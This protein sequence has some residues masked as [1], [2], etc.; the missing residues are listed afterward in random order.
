MSADALPFGW[1]EV[2]S[3]G[4]LPYYWNAT[5]GEASWSRPQFS[6]AGARPDKVRVAHLLLKHTGSRRP[7]TRTGELVTRSQAQATERLGELRRGILAKGRVTTGAA[8]S[9][10]V[11]AAFAETARDLSE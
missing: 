1:L 10:A 8:P 6:R 7:R 4:G 5:N 9:L 11:Q 3:S 2:Q